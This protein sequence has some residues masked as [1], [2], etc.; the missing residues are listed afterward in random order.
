MLIVRL[1]IFPAHSQVAIG[2]YTT[3]PDTWPEWTDDDIAQGFAVSSSMVYV[4]LTDRSDFVT[5]DVRDGDPGRDDIVLFDG[6]LRLGALTIAAPG[7]TSLPVLA[8][9]STA[10]EWKTVL[11]VNDRERENIRHI[12]VYLPEYA[13]PDMPDGAW[14]NI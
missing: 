10:A 7:T 12:T 6:T 13:D 4:G 3:D 2:D 8:L 9:S 11:T 14:M 5:V 1:P